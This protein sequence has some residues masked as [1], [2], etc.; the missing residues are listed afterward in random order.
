[1]MPSN[2]IKDDTIINNPTPRFRYKRQTQVES[3]HFQNFKPFSDSFSDSNKLL[4]RP[5]TLLYGW[6]NSGKSSILELI[7]LFSK[8]CEP[9]LTDSLVSFNANNLMGLGS[10]KNFIHQN[11][12]EKYF[13]VSYFLTGVNLSRPITIRTNDSI[14]KNFQ[15]KLRS[16]DI[17]VFLSYCRSYNDNEP[18]LSTLDSFGIIIENNIE[19]LAN[20]KND[21]FEITTLDIKFS[22]NSFFD[23]LFSKRNQIIQK[24]E[25]LSDNIERLNF[26]FNRKFEN[27][28]KEN[29]IAS[30][31]IIQLGILIKEN[32]NLIKDLYDNG[33]INNKI[34]TNSSNSSLILRTL[35]GQPKKT[36]KTERY[37]N[38]N[39]YLEESYG[40]NQFEYLYK[41]ID[42]IDRLLDKSDQLESTEIT[43]ILEELFDD[44]DSP[45]L[46]NEEYIRFLEGNLSSKQ[47]ALFW[48]MLSEYLPN[49]LRRGFITHGNET[50]YEKKIKTTKPLTKSKLDFNKKIV[51]K[52]LNIE[53]KYL[54]LKK[55][56]S[57]NIIDVIKDST[58]KLRSLFP[59]D[60]PF[61]RSYDEEIPVKIKQK[62]YEELIDILKNY[63][64]ADTTSHQ[65]LKKIFFDNLKKSIIFKTKDSSKNF[66]RFQR[67][68]IEVRRCLTLSDYIFEYLPNSEIEEDNFY[69]L[70][71][72]I[73]YIFRE[74]FS[75]LRRS[76]RSNSYKSPNLNFKRYFEKR[77][78]ND[79]NKEIISDE[80]FEFDHVF[81]ILRDDKITLEKVNES[82]KKMGFDFNLNFEMLDG[83]NDEK[84]FYALAKNLTNS[85][86][87]TNVVDLGLGLKKIIP[88]VTYLYFRNWDGII[89]IQEPESNLHPKFQAEIAEIL[90]DS[91]K[92]N[93]NIHIV[94]THSEIMVLR[95][96]KLIK[97]KKVSHKDVSINFIDKKNGVSSIKNIGINE[98]GEFTSNWPKGFFNERIDELI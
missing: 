26:K 93:G 32:M 91:Y 86:I 20:K 73:Y 18:N 8:I 33:Y 70:Q 56:I 78:I 37:L 7:Q 16:S 14:N 59:S 89:C 39:E 87:N 30:D 28:N 84:L 50:V 69:L 97:Q 82:L 95:L 45:N 92:K 76:S 13:N 9:S 80:K 38:L 57:R 46:Q 60:I 81:N 94:E 34:L 41:A 55:E 77:D 58:L 74:C 40:L 25:I 35:I 52:L 65:N 11:I 67:E 42:T 19:I 44:L 23:V 61:E 83:K 68:P 4:I 43:I 79:F 31:L 6:N 62:D 3:I 2:K 75:A 90:T 66:F 64:D 53:L 85:L 54:K 88:L 47:T 21:L 24:L 48:E 27:L 36:D 1:M 51:I 5:I 49:N 98:K 71:K 72:N 96:L 12:K 63:K 17:E 29:V 15:K 10:Y 22:T